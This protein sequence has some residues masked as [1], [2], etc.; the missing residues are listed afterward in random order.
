[1]SL[2]FAPSTFATSLLSSEVPH[3]PH[4]HVPLAQGH[5]VCNLGV[6]DKAGGQEADSV[7]DEAQAVE[8]EVEVEMIE[9][10]VKEELRVKGVEVMAT[11]NVKSN[12]KLKVTVMVKANADLEVELE[13][14]VE[15]EGVGANQTAHQVGS[16]GDVSE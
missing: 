3:R 2:L 11:A 12:V 6:L 1:M 15:V 5:V 4:T 14:R 7:E 10:E 9:E 16:D 13:V 8:V